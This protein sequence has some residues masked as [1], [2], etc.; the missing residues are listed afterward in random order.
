MPDLKDKLVEAHARDQLD[1]YVQ[2][3]SPGQ[4]AAFFARVIPKLMV[5]RFAL[6]PLV[7][8]EYAIRQ[9]K[10]IYDHDMGLIWDWVKIKDVFDG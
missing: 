4:R 7:K 6:C 10:Q 3:M 5:A 1:A 9:D 8:L 2:R